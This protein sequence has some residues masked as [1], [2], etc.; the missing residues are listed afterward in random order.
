MAL[1]SKLEREGWSSSTKKAPK[2]EKDGGENVGTV[3]VLNVRKVVM[4]ASKG[5]C[6]GA[7]GGRRRGGKG[8]R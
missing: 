3:G 7:E 6:H 8:K 1:V 2:D 5:Q 4:Y